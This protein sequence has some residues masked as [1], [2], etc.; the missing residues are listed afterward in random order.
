MYTRNDWKIVLN[1]EIFGISNDYIYY[2]DYTPLL[3]AAFDGRTE[4]VKFL[5]SKGSSLEEKNNKGN[6]NI[7]SKISWYLHKST[8]KHINKFFVSETTLENVYWMFTVLFI[9]GFF[10]LTK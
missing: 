9:E 5:V 6:L 3:K 2:I 7:I 10:Y 1:V 4:T 8:L